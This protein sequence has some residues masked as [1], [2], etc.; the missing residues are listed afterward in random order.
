[1]CLLG[2][3]PPH[4]QTKWEVHTLIQIL[5]PWFVTIILDILTHIL[6]TADKYFPIFP[7]LVQ[8]SIFNIFYH[9]ILAN[10]LSCMKVSDIISSSVVSDS[11]RLHE[12][13]IAHQVSL[14]MEFSRQEHR[15]GLPFPSLGDL[16]NPGIKPRSPAFQADSSPSEPQGKSYCI[17]YLCIVLYIYLF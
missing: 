10:R 1:M 7:T 13:H 3:S 8:P 15:S 14:S 4:V 2:P 5:P 17:L 6:L 9:F 11:L 16:P 12:L